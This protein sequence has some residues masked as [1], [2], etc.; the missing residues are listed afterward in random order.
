MIVGSL[1]GANSDECSEGSVVPDFRDASYFAGST[2]PTR[3]RTDGA[4]AALPNSPKSS[5][6]ISGLAS[7]TFCAPICLAIAAE[8][9]FVTAGSL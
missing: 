8:S 6:T 4:P 1:S 2:A 9:R 7:S 5:A 3:S